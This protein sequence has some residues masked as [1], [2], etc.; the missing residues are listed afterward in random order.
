LIHRTGGGEVAIKDTPDSGGAVNVVAREVIGTADVHHAHLLTGQR[1]VVAAARF[2]ETDQVAPDFII[3]AAIIVDA[4]GVVHADLDQHS[5]LGLVGNAAIVRAVP[6]IKYGVNAVVRVVASIHIT[7]GHVVVENRGDV[8]LGATN[9]NDIGAV[10]IEVADGLDLVVVR[11]QDVIGISGVVCDIVGT[12]FQIVEGGVAAV[13][14]VIGGTTSGVQ[15]V[16][17]ADIVATGAGIHEPGQKRSNVL[18]VAEI[19]AIDIRTIDL[20]GVDLIKGS[21]SSGPSGVGVAQGRRARLKFLDVVV[22]GVVSIRVFT[23]EGNPTVRRGEVGAT[24]AFLHNTH[25]V[26]LGNPFVA[27]ART[28]VIGSNDG[29]D[30]VLVDSAQGVLTITVGNSVISIGTVVGVIVPV[31]IVHDDIRTERFLAG[32]NART[33]AFH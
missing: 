21:E 22:A 14:I 4:V 7:E 25:V 27:I 3:G 31:D 20:A 13:H 32:R 18:I 1:G 28:V 10:I 15:T 5:L 8:L 29:G 23:A 19:G 24:S 6:S 9:F 26:S 17:G 16:S 12:I 33:V 2:I 11:R 30:K